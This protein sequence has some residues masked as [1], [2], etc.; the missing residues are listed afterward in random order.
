MTGFTLVTNKEHEEMV[1]RALMDAR[2]LIAKRRNWAKGSMWGSGGE[3]FCAIAAVSAASGRI[4]V[5]DSAEQLLA[6]AIDPDL[7]GNKLRGY[8]SILDYNDKWYR[9]HKTVLKKFDEAIRLAGRNL[10]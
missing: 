8:W 5:R 4:Q 6:E 1:L 2:A 9:R 7:A 10:K 3:K